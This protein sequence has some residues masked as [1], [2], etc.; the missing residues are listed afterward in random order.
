MV[1]RLRSSLIV[2][3]GCSNFVMEKSHGDDETG[4]TPKPNMDKNLPE[5]FTI[6]GV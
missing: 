1:K 6:G 4:R 5:G 3:D 2:E